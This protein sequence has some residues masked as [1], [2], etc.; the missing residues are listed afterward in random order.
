ME[1]S[2][3][4]CG[5]CRQ[6]SITEKEQVGALKRKEHRCKIH[7]LQVLHGRFHPNLDRLAICHEEETKE[8]E[9]AKTKYINKAYVDTKIHSELDPGNSDSYSLVYSAFL[10][11]MNNFSIEDNY[12]KFQKLLNLVS[13]YEHN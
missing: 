1:Y 7:K 10:Q 4:F 11:Y 3:D 2:G 5:E 9:I 8:K 13:N 6:L 12:A